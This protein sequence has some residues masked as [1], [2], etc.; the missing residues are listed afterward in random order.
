MNVRKH[1]LGRSNRNL[2]AL[3][4]RIRLLIKRA[5]RF[6]LD[7]MRNTLVTRLAQQR[8]RITDFLRNLVANDAISK[9]DAQR[10]LNYLTNTYRFY[11]T[12]LVNR[13]VIDVI[14]DFMQRQSPESQ[15]AF[16]AGL[17]KLMSNLIGMPPNEQEN[18][19]DM[20]R[21]GISPSQPDQQ[22]LLD[23]QD[24]PQIGEPLTMIPL[25]QNRWLFLSKNRADA[26]WM[27]GPNKYLTPVDHQ[28]VVEL[29]KQQPNLRKQAKNV[30]FEYR[31]PYHPV[32]FVRE[33]ATGKSFSI[34]SEEQIRQYLPGYTPQQPTQQN[35][36]PFAPETTQLPTPGRTQQRPNAGKRSAPSY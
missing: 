16:I 36:P 21:Q 20:V 2:N 11:G 14:M 9:E 17:E 34:P 22:S 15:R 33:Q 19:L 1:Y 5:Q 10:L 12:D 3:E 6:D 30:I 23:R 27:G 18:V 31:S 35:A 32:Y 8:W 25:G 26:A 28:Y 24:Q 7:E 13:K 29:L 4:A